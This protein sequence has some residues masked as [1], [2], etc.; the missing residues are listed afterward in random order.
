MNLRGRLTMNA[1]GSCKSTFGE[2]RAVLRHWS[3]TSHKAALVSQN[4]SMPGGACELTSVRFRNST[5]A[6]WP[7]LACLATRLIT[8]CAR[9]RRGQGCGLPQPIQDVQ[10]APLRDTRLTL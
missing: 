8:C 1:P 3:A 7:T 2:R 5:T 10:H 6:L 4:A 9:G